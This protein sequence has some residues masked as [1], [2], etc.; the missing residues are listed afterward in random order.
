MIAT[1]WGLSVTATGTA[2][3]T[4]DLVRIGFGVTHLATEPAAAFAGARAVVAA[5]RAVLG[6]HRVA[7]DAV[8][9]A[10][11]RL[12]TVWSYPEGRQV[13]DGHQCDA[14][15]VVETRTP[16]DAPQLMVDLIAAGVTGIQSVDFDVADREALLDHARRAAMQA[17]R[18]KA[19]LLAEAGG[20]R[21][22]RV[23]HIEDGDAGGGGPAVAFKADVA[24][25]G[26]PPGRITVTA[27]VTVGYALEP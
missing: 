9:D 3:A 8:L 25:P 15:F 19:E 16:D 18:R 7:A 11:L 17:A 4:P 6:E 23:L 12:T 13:L 1:P 26:L 20:V 21:V 10:H 22:G 5:V 27:G 14:T 24:D 2:Q